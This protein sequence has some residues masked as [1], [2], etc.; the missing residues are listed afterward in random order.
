MIMTIPGVTVSLDETGDVPR[1]VVTI[2]K[3]TKLPAAFVRLCHDTAGNRGATIE[4]KA[5]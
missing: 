4:W 1:L 5:A 2:P 3:G